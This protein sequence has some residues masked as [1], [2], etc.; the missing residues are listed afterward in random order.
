MNP[1]LFAIVNAIG[2][3]VLAGFIVIQWIAG[4]RV[5]RSLHDEAAG[6]IREHNLRID[7][8][9]HAAS[10]ESDI[11]G[12]KASIDSIR[13]DNEE[14]TRDLVARAGESEAMHTGLTQAQDQIK[15]ME[16]AV[17]ARDEA[18]KT[19]DEKLKEL[20]DGLSA[21]RKRL[22]EAVAKLKQAAEP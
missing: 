3:V 13:A 20:S 11:D 17:K 5:E 16:E 21:T 8:E 4:D 12:L 10:L 14:K 22:D 6:R 2:C 7:A 9:T 18:I 1:R 15:V 19:R